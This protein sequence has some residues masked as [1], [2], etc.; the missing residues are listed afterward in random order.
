M[1]SINSININKI[2]MFNSGTIKVPN[3]TTDSINNSIWSNQNKTQKE[4]GTNQKILDKVNEE[5]MRI[6]NAH[7]IEQE[8]KQAKK[9]EQILKSSSIPGLSNVGTQLK[10]KIDTLASE[11]RE[12]V[13]SLLD[14]CAN[15]Q[16]TSDVE[17]KAKKV[18]Q[19]IIQK[20]QEVVTYTQ[21]MQKAVQLDAKI[22]KLAAD[23]EKSKLLTKIDL[24]KIESKFLEPT[25]LNNTGAESIGSNTENSIENNTENDDI[26]N[27]IT[28]IIKY[29]ETGEKNKQIDEYIKEDNNQQESDKNNNFKLFTNN[30]N[31]LFSTNISDDKKNI[32]LT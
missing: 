7:T 2:N 10:T 20:R 28:S 5:Q 27:I 9:A 1:N 21:R 23:P 8:Q 32:F 3:S 13:M 11:L 17:E 18:E 16:T 22:S 26:S 29:I 12:L 4:D 14:K 31:N 24:N 15:C 6:A 19:E 25:N 30:K